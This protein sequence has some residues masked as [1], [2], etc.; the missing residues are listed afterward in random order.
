MYVEP[1]IEARSC[2]RRCRGK[3]MSITYSGCV[4]VA[5]IIQHAMGMRRSILLF[6]VFLAVPYFSA[7]RLKRH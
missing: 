4:F 1:N 7:L 3:V 6:M 5:L 2:I